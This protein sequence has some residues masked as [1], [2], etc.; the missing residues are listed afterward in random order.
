M[1]IFFLERNI[2][3]N[4]LLLQ[5]VPMNV[6]CLK[7]GRSCKIH[8]WAQMKKFPQNFFDVMGTFSKLWKV[9]EDIINALDDTVPVPLKDHI[10]GKCPG[11]NTWSLASSAFENWCYHNLKSIWQSRSQDTRKGSFNN[12]WWSRHLNKLY[13]AIHIQKKNILNFFKDKHNR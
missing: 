3:E 11:A 2:V 4:L 5:P 1:N 8:H 13:W 10:K 6:R 7:N 9:P 12:G